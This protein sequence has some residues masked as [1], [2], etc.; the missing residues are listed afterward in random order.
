MSSNRGGRIHSSLSW[1]ALGVA[2]LPVLM[3]IARD[4]M[5]APHRRSYL[6]A[7]VLLLLCAVRGPS[8]VAA[9]RRD[10]LAL[11]LVAVIFQFFGIASD[12]ALIGRLGLALAVVGMA[13][14]H[15]SPKWTV[16]VLAF[17]AIPVPGAML[18]YTTPSL[19]SLWGGAAEQ[20]VQLLGGAVNRSGPLFQ[21][22][23]GRLEL[24]A[25]DGGIPLL[26]VLMELGWYSGIRREVSGWALLRRVALGALAAAPIQLIGITIAVFLF[27]SGFGDVARTWLNHGLWLA[28]AACVI[29]HVERRSP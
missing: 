21:T 7:P 18:A 26:A 10:G 1:V 29:L 20:F 11:M 12:T 28:V 25:T 4:F 13:R 5:I 2:F 16:A 6:L 27:A 15:G 19:E 24:V 14:W 23:A 17:G 3:G 22:S 8:Q 9:P